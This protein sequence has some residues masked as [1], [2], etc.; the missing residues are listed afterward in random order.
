MRRRFFWSIFGVSSILVIL[1]AATVVGVSNGVRDRATRAEL[2]R[3]GDAIGQVLGERLD[4]PAALRALQQGTPL[5]ELVGDLAPLRLVAG[6]SDIDFY[7]VGPN[8]IFGRAVPFDVEVDLDALRDGRSTLSEAAAPNGSTLFVY[9]TPIAELPQRDV[10]LVATV[11]R[12]APV[13]VSLPRGWFVVVMAVAA[14]LAAVLARVLS[15]R[16][17]LQLDSVAEAAGRLSEGDLSARAE[18]AGAAEIDAV[19]TAFNEMAEAMAASRDRE[20]QF[21][22]SVGHDLR[23]PLTTITGYAEALEDGVGDESEV[24]RIAGVMGVEGRRLRRLIEDVMLLARLESA[25]FDL[26]AEP[27]EVSPF[28]DEILTPFRDRAADLRVSW[29]QD[30]EGLAN[31]GL[32]GTVSGPGGPRFARLDPDRIGQVVGNL[33]ENALRYTPGAGS[34]DAL[35]RFDDRDLVIEIADSGPGIDVDDLPH[36]FDRFYVARRHRAVRPEGSGLGL[37]IARRLVVAMGGSVHAEQR[38]GGGTTFVVRIPTN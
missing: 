18:A 22:L 33:V 8:G 37:S 19:A 26:R 5:A 13:D 21:L 31:P 3:A 6:G 20:R 34:V 4:R 32:V 15:R 35:A 14:G 1:L 9:A 16:L 12:A 25:D 7:A 11:A 23:T 24:R 10:V 36:V 38:R 30:L 29:S 2:E 28:L 17:T 27:V